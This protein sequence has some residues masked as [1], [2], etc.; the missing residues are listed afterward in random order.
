MIRTIITPQN[1]DIHISIPSEYVGK[2]IE[3]LL[4]TSDAVK[5][6]SAPFVKSPSL[7]G[8]LKLTDAQSKDFHNY[9]KD[10]RN[11]WN[12]DI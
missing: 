7:R 5:E 8:K 6:E 4:Y 11:E 10:S 12:R 1:T 3:V 9:L 2:R